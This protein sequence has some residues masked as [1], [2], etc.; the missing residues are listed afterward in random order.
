MS[1]VLQ[2]TGGNISHAARILGIDRATL[3]NKMKRYQLRRDGEEETE[4]T[5]EADSH[6][7]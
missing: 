7:G 2:E 6:S 3:Y 4:A 1:A 5:P